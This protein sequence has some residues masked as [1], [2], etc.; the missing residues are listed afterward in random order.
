[1]RKIEFADGLIIL[2]IILLPL[3]FYFPMLFS[4]EQLTKTV[5]GYE[6]DLDLVLWFL[7]V[8]L[9][10]IIMLILWYFTC[11]H[12]WRIVVLIPLTIELF[13]LISFLNAKT[14]VFDE[15]DFITSAPIT[16]PILALIIFLSRKVSYYS[17]AKQ[18]NESLNTEIDEIFG[19]IYVD[20]IRDELQLM[21]KFHDLKKRKDDYKKNEYLEKLLNIRKD[22]Y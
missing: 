2:L 8:K 12:W 10:I 13:K 19:K 20:S 18:I 15:I 7:A 16:I 6:F 17:S 5:E 11:R 3:L 22:I 9:F 14:E 4:E 1:M 21:K